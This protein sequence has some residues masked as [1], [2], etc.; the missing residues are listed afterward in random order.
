MSLR[1][2]VEAK[3]APASSQQSIPALLFAH[4]HAAPSPVTNNPGKSVRR[5]H[6]RWNQT[7]SHTVNVLF[8]FADG[9]GGEPAHVLL[10][11]VIKVEPTEHAKLYDYE[12]DGMLF[13]KTTEHTKM[14]T[15]K[16]NTYL[17]VL[18]DGVYE[19]HDTWLIGDPE[20]KLAS[21]VPHNEDWDKYQR[22]A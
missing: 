17:P 16:K 18:V 5:K 22:V 4:R 1:P 8:K 12:D 21:I 10:T 14:F 11:S 13:Y 7:S 15:T 19:V 20:E 9:R 3:T 2:R 6:R